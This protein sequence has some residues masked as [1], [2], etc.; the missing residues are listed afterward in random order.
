MGVLAS[1]RNY[2]MTLLPVNEPRRRWRSFTLA[3]RLQRSA[4]L[5]VPRAESI[6]VAAIARQPSL[7]SNLAGHKKY[8]HRLRTG[9]LAGGVVE[10]ALLDVRVG[11]A[12]AEAE[13]HIEGSSVVTTVDDAKETE[14]HEWWR[15]GDATLSTRDMFEQRFALRQ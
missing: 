13:K 4:A 2:I 8:L 9:V 12:T 1:R 6:S 15:Q 10:N 14:A 5:T 7:G 3:T 11:R